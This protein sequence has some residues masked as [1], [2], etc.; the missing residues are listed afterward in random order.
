[1]KFELNDFHRNIPDEEL[2][3]DVKR[4]AAKINRGTLSAAEYKR[5]GKYGVTTLCRHF[6]SWTIVLEKCDIPLNAYQ[7]GASQSGH[8]HRKVS[9]EE[10]LSDIKGVAEELGV[11]TL[12]SH[13]YEQYGKFSRDICFRRFSSWN[14]ALEAAGLAPYK[15]VSGKRLDDET[16]LVEIERMWIALGRQPTTTDVKNGLSNFTLNT[17]SRHFGGWRGAL[18]AFVEWVNGDNSES[19]EINN[20]PNDFNIR[21]QQEVKAENPP[22]VEDRVKHSTSREISLRLRFR[23]MQ[24]D[25]FKCCICGASP[26]KDPSV[27][28]HIDHIKPWSKGGETTIENLQT[29]C[30][31]CNLGKSDL[32][33]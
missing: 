5:F 7:V 11:Q 12:S 10:L 20:Q 6:G 25:N 31:K 1:M 26:A 19:I 17:F 32:I 22:T 27:E 16:L 33:V 24:R 8:S 28:L 2:L 23:V 30:S 13:D 9:T 29:L 14:E 3:E 18:Q 21:K 4:I 15:Y